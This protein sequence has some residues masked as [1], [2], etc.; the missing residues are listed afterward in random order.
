MEL[1]A[2]LQ[3]EAALGLSAQAIAPRCHK[4]GMDSTAAEKRA[5]QR[6]VLGLPEPEL[7]PDFCCVI[8]GEVMVDPVLASDGFT[9]ERVAIMQWIRQCGWR[10]RSPVT[11]ESLQPH[12]LIP[13]H[14]LKSLIG[15]YEAQVHSL[16]VNVAIERRVQHEDAL[17]QVAALQA[18]VATLTG[19]IEDLE[20]QALAAE[21]RHH[22]SASPA[23]PPPRRVLAVE[24]VA[25]AESRSAPP[26]AAEP[27]PAPAP[28]PSPRA[29][30]SRLTAAELRPSPRA[31][32]SRLT[33][34]ELRELRGVTGESSSAAV[35]DQGST[36]RNQWG[37]PR[38][39]SCNLR[40]TLEPLTILSLEDV[41]DVAPPLSSTVA[42]ARRN[43]GQR[44]TREDA[45]EIRRWRVGCIGAQQTPPAVEAQ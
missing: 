42:V 35:V 3:L 28:L 21:M 12:L 43:L 37:A 33:A 4:R 40:R 29:Q 27:S 31:Q 9:Y 19:E 22:L 36:Q 11:N 10:P 2:A 23:P 14:R 45:N 44:L 6:H 30:G 38:R 16:L 26:A 5:Q 41:K 18:Q 25:A 8:T 15:D 20:A 32:G 34:A 1:R 13:N 39:G 24:P 17:Q 7:P